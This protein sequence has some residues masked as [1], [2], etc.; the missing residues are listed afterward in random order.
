MGAITSFVPMV[1]WV[2]ILQCLGS[3]LASGGLTVATKWA[4]VTLIKLL[5]RTY[6]KHGGLT[7][8]LSKGLWGV[9]PLSGPRCAQVALFLAFAWLTRP[10]VVVD[11]DPELVDLTSLVDGVDSTV[12][13]KDQEDWI[14]TFEEESESMKCGRK[15]R[16]AV[17]RFALIAK[18]HFGKMKRTDA[19]EA[20][21]HRFIYNQMVDHGI[22]P[23]HISSLITMSVL[24]TF[25]PSYSEMRAAQASLCLEWHKR[26]E[27][28]RSP[29]AS[30]PAGPGL[31]FHS[32]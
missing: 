12:H 2:S 4:V 23:S 6:A 17:A 15:S 18:G 16:K 19:N 20:V 21:V 24:L 11:D 10:P 7:A 31:K 28:V 29:S 22:R 1:G 32:E 27:F 26:E 30:G 13:T 9:F 25:V 14:A 8:M 5:N 3:L